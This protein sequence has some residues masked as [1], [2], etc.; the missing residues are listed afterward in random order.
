[1][2][3]VEIFNSWVTFVLLLGVG[4]AFLLFGTPP[5]PNDTKKKK[6]KK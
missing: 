1:M 3:F 2:T 6:S 4:M 5:T